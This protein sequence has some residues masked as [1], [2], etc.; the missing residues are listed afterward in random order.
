VGAFLL[1]ALGLVLLWFIVITLLRGSIVLAD[2]SY[3]WLE[4]IYGVTFGL[5]ILA[6]PLALFKFTR[7][8]AGLGYQIASYVFGFIT[9]LWCLLLTFSIWG[10]WGV[11]IGIFIAGVGIYPVAMVA[12]ALH[13][14]WSTLGEIVLAL[15]IAY[16]V[17]IFGGYLI[18]KSQEETDDDGLR[19]VNEEQNTEIVADDSRF[20]PPSLPVFHMNGEEMNHAL[21]SLGYDDFVIATLSAADSIKV[22]T[23]KISCDYIVH[24]L[25]YA[26]LDD[27][28]FDNPAAVQE[29]LR[30]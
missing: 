14:L 25:G 19:V 26:S 16:G 9:W 11:I 6:L 5:C 23:E 28:I 15:I 29:W 13:G 18:V 17:R 7:G 3:P 2:K 4:G 10:M 20:A 22:I 1:C 24:Q 12:T 27:L 21:K 30:K 8:Y